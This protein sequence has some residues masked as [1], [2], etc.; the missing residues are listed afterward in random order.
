LKKNCFIT[1][2]SIQYQNGEKSE[3]ELITKADYL[4]KDNL[5]RIS[6]KDTAT[7]GF[8]GC[9][10]IIKVKGSSFATI[11]RTGFASS[12]LSLETG[13]KHFCEY[14]T[15]FGSMQI[16]IYTHKVENNLKEKGSLYLKYTLDLNS[17][18][19]SDNEIYLTINS[20]IKNQ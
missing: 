2:K 9:T 3:S 11:S 17:S 1:L 8:E 12:M 7:T 18:Y 19:L 15:P 5:Y 13:K 14:E 20:D 16:G 10:T 6:Y 4:C